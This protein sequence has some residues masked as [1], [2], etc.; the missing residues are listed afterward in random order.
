MAR[1]RNTRNVLVRVPASLRAERAYNANVLSRGGWVSAGRAVEPPRPEGISSY[2]RGRRRYS[3]GH[4][5]KA[6]P[7]AVARGNNAGAR[8][9]NCLFP[10]AWSQLIRPTKPYN[11]TLIAWRLGPYRCFVDRTSG[12]SHLFPRTA[13]IIISYYL[14]NK[15]LPSGI[16]NFI[17]SVR[18]IKHHTAL[19]AMQ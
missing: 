4:R 2:S 17:P 8:E 18:S 16:N 3:R 11:I 14:Y 9:N 7:K 10:R 12:I 15:C 6:P 5:A 1:T 13:L 19:G